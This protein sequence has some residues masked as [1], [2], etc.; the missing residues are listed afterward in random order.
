MIDLLAIFAHRDDAE[1]GCGGTLAKAARNGYNVGILDLTQGE[2]GTRGSAE[3][4][5]AEAQRAAKVLGASV[6]ENLELPDAGIVNEPA[7]REKLARA[8]RRLQPK[9]V[10]APALEGRHPDHRTAAQLVRDACFVSGLSKVAPD[11]PKY[12][13][14]KILHCMTYRQD[15]VRPSFIVDVSDDF[16]KK[17]ESVRCYAS[18]FEGVTQ[19]GEV[20]PN[21]EPLED[22]VRHYGAYY[23]TLI[24]KRYGEPFYTTEMTEIDDVLAMQV[25]TL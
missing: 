20:Y 1:L 23:G 15:Y 5:A 4:R 2:M 18:Q 21:G 3:I 10:I 7:T 9:V 22:V 17:L 8:I 12:R 13:P 19:A 6:R 25:S 16:E 11:T 24:R 14:L